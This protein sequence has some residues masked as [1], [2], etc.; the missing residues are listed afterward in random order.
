MLISMTGQGQSRRVC[1]NMEI[2]VEVRA[3]NNRFFK[4]QLRTSDTLSRLE[5][6]IEAACRQ[7]VRRGSLN[8]SVYV[9]REARAA[10]FRLQEVAIASYHAQIKSIAEKLGINA[11][12]SMGQLL[13][14]PGVVN[15][16]ETDNREPSDELTKETLAAVEDALKCL[17]RMREA[18]G[19]NMATELLAQ[20]DRIRVLKDAI[21]EKAPLVIDDYRERLRLRVQQGLALVGAEVHPPTCCVRRRY[22]RI[23]PMCAKRS[24]DCAVTLGSLPL[25][26][27][28]KRARVASWIS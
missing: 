14:L 18:E 7:H 23:R 22:L 10:D 6:E 16:N 3:V 28:I 24:F 26:L 15:E 21:E 5:S 27:K 11:D 17:N 20:V 1:G 2:Q 13:A 8:M 9:N 19:A 25:W 12:V 4:L